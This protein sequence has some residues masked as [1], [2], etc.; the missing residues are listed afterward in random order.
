MPVCSC[1]TLGT[2]DMN[3]R[4]SDGEG[5]RIRGLEAGGGA[6]LPS[7]PVGATR[8]LKLIWRHEN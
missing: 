5:V 2:G 3:R 8:D 6:S 1:T 4:V 7:I